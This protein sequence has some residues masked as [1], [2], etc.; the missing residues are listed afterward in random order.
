MFERFKGWISFLADVVTV[1]V[2]FGVSAGAIAA[3]IFGIVGWLTNVPWF[4][5]LTI[6]PVGAAGLL[7]SLH[8]W[9]ELYE[10]KTLEVLVRD[11]RDL[12]SYMVWQAA[13]LWI[14]VPPTPKIDEKHKAYP[15]LQKIKAALVAGHIQSV[16]GGTGMA[17]R[18]TRDQLLKLADL[19]V[20]QPVFL[21]PSQQEQQSP[22][23]PTRDQ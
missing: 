22:Q 11:W 9:R 2:F 17:A 12:D 1:S 8:L 5:I 23:S 16:Y 15:A 3:I 10:S 6:S 18:V 21:F 4:W 19:R 13:C 7:Y 14:G 20:E